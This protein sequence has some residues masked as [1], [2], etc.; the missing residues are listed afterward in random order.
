MRLNSIHNI[1]FFVKLTSEARKALLEDRF[2]K[3]YKDFFDRYR[4]EEDHSEENAVHRENRRK[5]FEKK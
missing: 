5:K 2:P 4:V 3:F 1:H